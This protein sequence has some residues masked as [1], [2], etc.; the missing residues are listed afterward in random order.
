MAGEEGLLTQHGRADVHANPV[1]TLVRD[2]IPAQPRATAEERRGRK[3]RDHGPGLRVTWP[4]AR[5]WQPGPLSSARNRERLVV[6]YLDVHPAP[7]PAVPCAATQGRALTHPTSRRRHGRSS[8]RPS[9]STARSDICDWISTTRE[10]QGTA[11]PWA[12]GGSPAARPPRRRLTVIS[13]PAS[14]RHLT[15]GF[16][17]HHTPPRHRPPDGFPPTRPHGRDPRPPVGFPPPRLHSRDPFPWRAP[18]ARPRLTTGPLPARAARQPRSDRPRRTSACTSS[19]RPHRR[20]ATRER[21][22]R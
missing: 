15:M 16:H 3:C 1:V 6:W 22:K 13:A 9:S 11:R 2:V 14:P 21:R 20:T 12:A 10:L 17:H 4:A 5:L 19:P 7:A 18:P 8:G